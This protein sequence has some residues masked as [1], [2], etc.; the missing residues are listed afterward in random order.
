ML[1]EMQSQSAVAE[2]LGL[3]QAYVSRIARGEVERVQKGTIAKVEDAMGW[4]RGCIGG[5][6]SV[7]LAPTHAPTARPA[8][9]YDLV[10]AMDARELRAF[11]AWFLAWT[12]PLPA[13]RDELERLIRNDETEAPR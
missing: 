13:A 1:E 2:R 9:A 3:S 7:A 4:Q 11:R 12:D 6:A 8:D 5:P 10:R